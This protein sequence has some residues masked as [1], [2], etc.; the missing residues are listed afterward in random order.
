MTGI[1]APDRFH[2]IDSEFP[3]EQ[4]AFLVLADY[5]EA[6]PRGEDLARFKPVLTQELAY[7]LRLAGGRSLCLFTARE[8]IEYAFRGSQEDGIEGLEV[9][10]HCRRKVKSCGNPGCPLKGNGTYT[11]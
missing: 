8:R 7:F 6:A 4:R 1:V 10:R 2:K 3:Y 9:P 11:S 5:L